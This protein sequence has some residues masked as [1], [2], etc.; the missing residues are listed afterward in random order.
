MVHQS[1]GDS[2]GGHIYGPTACLPGRLSMGALRDKR[3]NEGFE[4]NKQTSKSFGRGE[5]S[6]VMLEQFDFTF[7][8]LNTALQ[9]YACA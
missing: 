7:D 8:S 4:I 9:Y 1:Q 3:G 2:S 6:H 5:L